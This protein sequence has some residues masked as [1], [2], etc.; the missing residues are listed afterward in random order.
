MF[1][2]DWQFSGHRFIGEHVSLIYPNGLTAIGTVQKYLPPDG[3]DEA[4]FHILHDDG[5]KEDLDIH[6]CFAAMEQY[7]KN[8]STLDSNSPFAR[9]LESKVVSFA[10]LMYFKLSVLMDLSQ[11]LDMEVANGLT[12]KTLSY[13]ILKAYKNFIS[14]NS[15]K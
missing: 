1:E 12:R 6:E 11:Y 13:Q 4:L 5:D 8:F 10:R 3:D 15:S 2:Y 7:R 9:H 14:V